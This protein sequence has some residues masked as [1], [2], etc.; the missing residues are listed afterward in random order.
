MH[1]IEVTQ[2]NLKLAYTIQKEIFSDS[3]DIL[4]IKNS[5]D[6]NDPG[7]AY[8]IVYE[9]ETAIGISGIYTVE[10]DRDSVWLSWYGVLPKWRSKGF[11][12]KILLESIEELHH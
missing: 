4:H 3:P 10:A 5:I 8:W 7:Y 9:N 12:R 11:G 6:N 1:F 2:Q